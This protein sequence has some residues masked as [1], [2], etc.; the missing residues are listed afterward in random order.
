M[1]AAV[2]VAVAAELAGV[3]ALESFRAGD[4]PSFLS[5]TMTSGTAGILEPLKAATMALVGCVEQSTGPEARPR[6]HGC[7][8]VDSFCEYSLSSE[9]IRVSVPRP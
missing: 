7:N 4:N 1:E 6:G 3:R 5:K 2:A 9:A 8:K